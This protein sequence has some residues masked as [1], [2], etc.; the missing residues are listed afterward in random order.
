MIAARAGKPHSDP[1][2]VA[3]AH[4]AVLEA[5]KKAYQAIR[6]AWTTADNAIDAKKVATSSDPARVK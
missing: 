6:A 4:A 1:T 5:S 3:K 2:D